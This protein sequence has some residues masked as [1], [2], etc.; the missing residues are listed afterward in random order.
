M[1]LPSSA[2]PSAQRW[3]LRW[4]ERR[5][6]SLLFRCGCATALMLGTA[7]LPAVKKKLHELALRQE[8]AQND[9]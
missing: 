6:L 5:M 7:A 8:A 9:V 1:R 2:G 4:S 3:P